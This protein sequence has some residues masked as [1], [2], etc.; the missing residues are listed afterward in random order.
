MALRPPQSFLSHQWHTDHRVKEVIP[1]VCIKKINF[2]TKGSS[3]PTL[4]YT[5][6]GGGKP[7]TSSFYII[8]R[9]ELTFLSIS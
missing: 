4:R 3:A 2:Y 6:P 5:I 8:M 7:V 1:N 9:Q